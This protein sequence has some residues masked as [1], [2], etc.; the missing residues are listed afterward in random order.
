MSARDAHAP[1]TAPASRATFPAGFL[2]GAAT[3]AYQ[4]EGSPLADG[5][6]PSNWHRFSH[7]PGC[8]ANGETGDIACDHYRRWEEDVEWMTKLGL[9]AYRFSLA[10]SRIQPEGRGIVNPKGLAFY[11]RLVDRLLERGI[12]PMVTLFHWDLP[13]ALDD[14]GGWLNPD[15]VNWFADYAEICYRALGDRVPLWA[16][17][18]EPWVVMDAGF[19][20]GTHAPGHRSLYEP[21]IAAHHMLRAHAAAVRCYRTEW[22]RSI[23]LVVNLEPKDPETASAEDRAATERADAWMNRMYL[24]PVYLGRPAEGL[25]EMYGDAWV[26]YPDSDYAEMREPLDFLGINYYTRGV[27]R[28]DPSVLPHRSFTVRGT[29]PGFTETNWE[30]HPA[31]LTRTLTWV[32]ERYGRMPIYITENG[33]ALA[34][35]APR[36]GR[37][38]DPQRIAYYRDHLNA[39]RA[40]IE[41]G[42][43]VRGYFAWSLLDNFEWSAGYSKRFGLIGV[44]LSTQKR[45][46]KA[47]ADYYAGVV[48]SN[49]ESLD[50]HRP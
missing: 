44:D 12:Q 24:D 23:G 1:A 9:G 47:S 45:T 2:W 31:S 35:P 29:G 39:V 38:D 19:L 33:C 15:S 17:L 41:R 14:R 30:I 3:S 10:W 37:I 7:T 49:G 21:P 50:L 11:A 46:L 26:E 6:G 36:D 5:A 25:R 42:A 32:T 48:A 4:I 40:A 22:K 18:N 20:H 43:D 28:N 27:T 8:T 13:A 16:T 34:D